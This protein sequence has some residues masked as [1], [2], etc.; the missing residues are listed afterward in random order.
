[1]FKNKI[2]VT[3]LNFLVVAKTVVFV[4]LAKTYDMNKSIKRAVILEQH[5]SKIA[6]THVLAKLT[7]KQLRRML[8]KSLKLRHGKLDKMKVMYH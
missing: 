8:E 4:L 7:P 5:I 2:L 3:G 6:Q 1:M